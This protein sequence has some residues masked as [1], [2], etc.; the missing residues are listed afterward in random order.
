L[1]GVVEIAR[2]VGL[3]RLDALCHVDHAASWRVLE[4]CGFVREGVLRRHS[5]FPNLMAG[6]P[7]DVYCYALIL[8]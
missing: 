7:C 2:G 5:E 4:K 6:E 3:V 8:G 1:R